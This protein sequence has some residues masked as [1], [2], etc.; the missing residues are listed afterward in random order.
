MAGVVVDDGVVESDYGFIYR[1]SGPLV[2]A[3][4]M[5]GAAMYELV[6]VGHQKLVG[7]IIKLE[8]NTASIQVRA[9]QCIGLG[10]SGGC[11]RQD[12]TAAAAAIDGG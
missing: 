1:V 10:G 7:E 2:I 8:G 5:Q 11:G 4:N 6:R 9:F 3:D 12:S